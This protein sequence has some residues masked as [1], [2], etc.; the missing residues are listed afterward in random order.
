M[1]YKVLE[2]TSSE[3]VAR[4]A[5]CLI[6]EIIERTGIKHFDVDIP[7]TEDLCNNF[8][9]HG[10]YTVVGAID[11]DKI[12]GFGALCESHSLYAKGS[13]GIVQEFYILPEYRSKSVGSDLL[14]EIIELSKEKR[15]TRLELCTPPLPEFDR[16][17]SFYKENGFDITGGCKMKRVIAYRDRE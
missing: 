6:N 3:D 11:K 7:L 9:S 12:V 17:V 1:E 13:F 10:H 8:M 16:T 15:W 4:L 2:K 5:G 14:A